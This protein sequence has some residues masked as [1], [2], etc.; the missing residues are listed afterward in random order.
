MLDI[1]RLK[2]FLAVARSGSM[3]AAARELNIAQP[4]LS[5]HT[6]ELE[7]LTGVKLFDRL[8]RGVRLTPAGEVLA[9][10]AR[11]VLEAV[12]VAEF[13]MREH[14]DMIRQ[15][16]IVRLG[17]LP[18]WQT[19]YGEEI[20]KLARLRFPDLKLT[21][22]E[23]RNEEANRLVAGGELDIATTLDVE[24]SRFERP[25]AS[26]PMVVLSNRPLKPSYRFAELG[27]LDLVLTTMEH[28][29]RRLLEQETARRGISLRVVLEIDGHTALKN[30]VI[31]GLGQ[32]VY[33]T[34]AVRQE[35]EAGQLFAAPIVDYPG[36]RAIYLAH[37][38]AFD[39]RIARQFYHLLTSVAAGP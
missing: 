37:A 36:G 21:I 39:H 29:T 4:A 28:P 20:M 31:N 35:L 33:T 18:S 25:L 10:H 15:V 1:R 26:E 32:A 24:F 8:P 3:A 23:V 12:A 30:A 13:A 27:E 2:Y 5:H 6:A 34:V 16:G 22:M 7:R 38:D 19:N 11:Q 14:S 9:G 17:L